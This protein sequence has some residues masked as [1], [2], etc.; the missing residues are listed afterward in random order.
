MARL[1]A[2]NIFPFC[3]NVLMIYALSTSFDQ[4]VVPGCTNYWNFE[5]NFLDQMNPSTALFNSHNVSWVNNRRGDKESALYLNQRLH[6]NTKFN[7]VVDERF[8]NR[9]LGLCEEASVMW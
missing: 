3:L 1:A 5:K 6:T 7:S 2:K 4:F 8:F 9:S